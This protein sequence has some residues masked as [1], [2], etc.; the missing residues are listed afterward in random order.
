MNGPRTAREALIAELLGNVGKLH[1]AVQEL[2]ASLPREMNAAEERI[3]KM[4][5]L[6][7][8]AGDAYRETVKS[9]TASELGSIRSRLEGH[10]AETRKQISVDATVIRK[11]LESSVRQSLADIPKMIHSSVESTLSAHAHKALRSEQSTRWI[12]V[13][14][15]FVSAALGT[16][17]T[18]GAFAVFR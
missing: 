11:E 4:V 3:V 17:L 7:N 1:E 9:F 18:L 15:C 2:N 10:A 12:T 6:L 8:K 14:L 13:G 5:G 16:A